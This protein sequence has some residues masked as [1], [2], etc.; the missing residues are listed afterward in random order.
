MADREPEGWVACADLDEAFAV[1]ERIVRRDERR[2]VIAELTSNDALVRV[3]RVLL[4]L[5][6][7]ANGV[8]PATALRDLRGA[9]ESALLAPEEEG[10]ERNDKVVEGDSSENK[11][12]ITSA[13]SYSEPARAGVAEYR[14]RIL[15][16]DGDEADDCF[17]APGRPGDGEVAWWDERSPM[18]APHRAQISACGPW[19]DVTV[20]PPVAH[21]EGSTHG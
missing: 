2:K 18:G 15:D 17:P 16:T 3:H 21:E 4:H 12:G 7:S 19:E 8:L 5:G 14:F 10:G 6:W 13:S 1:V 20:E 11:P 9:L